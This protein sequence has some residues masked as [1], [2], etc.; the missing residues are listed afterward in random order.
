MTEGIVVDAS[1][2]IKWVVAEEHAAEAQAL[3][4][5]TVAA[6]YPLF[7]PPHLVSEV[8]NGLYRRV[9]RGGPTALTE[10]EA[11]AA[12]ERFLTFP[13][14]PEIPPTLYQ[15]AFSFAKT[16]QLPS[17]YD[18]LYVTLARLLDTE[19]WTADQRLLNTVGTLAPWVRW[20]GDY[21]STSR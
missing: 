9:R 7:V 19:L 21:A 15:E 11:T 10:D 12:V 6:H 14:Q 8:V 4:E 5:E 18:S 2:T 3:F 16:H 1:V 20:I 17:V 13:L